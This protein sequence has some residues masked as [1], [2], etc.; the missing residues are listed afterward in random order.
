VQ[1]LAREGHDRRRQRGREEQR[2]PLG[3]EVLQD[4]ADVGQEAHVEHAVRLVE[5]QH[6]E[7]LEAGVGEAEVVQQPAGGRDQDVDAPAERVLLRAHADAAEDAGA[8]ERG[9]DGQGLQMLRDL[10]GQLA[11]GREHEGARRPAGL[12]GETVEDREEEGGGLPAA[13]H[14]AREDVAA[15]EGRGDGRLLD[16]RGAREAELAHAAQQIRVEAEVGEGHGCRVLSVR[17]ACCQ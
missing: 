13:G 1:H 9:V 5:D 8:G 16:R 4:A 11:R 2:L 14:R 12:A 10:G 3:G 15:R 17:P 7:T 6:L